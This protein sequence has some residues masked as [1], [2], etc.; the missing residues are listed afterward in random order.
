MKRWFSISLIFLFLFAASIYAQQTQSGTPKL[1]V[2]QETFDAG[3][4]YK[5]DKLEHAFV[6]KN[7]GNS[8]L[9]IVSATPG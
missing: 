1:T 6:I 3:T 8:D 4:I 2:D 5:S 9:N 7:A